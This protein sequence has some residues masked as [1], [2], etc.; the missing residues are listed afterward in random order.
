M[1]TPLQKL[2]KYQIKRD[3]YQKSV[4][5]DKIDGMIQTEIKFSRLYNI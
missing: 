4:Q 2:K 1:L 5:K 3:K